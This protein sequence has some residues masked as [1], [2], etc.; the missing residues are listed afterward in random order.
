MLSTKFGIKKK[1]KSVHYDDNDDKP[2]SQQ[3]FITGGA[4]IIIGMHKAQKNTRCKHCA[5]VENCVTRVV[6]QFFFLFLSFILRKFSFILRRSVNN[7]ISVECTS[8]LTRAPVLGEQNKSELVIFYYVKLH[9][10][11]KT[12]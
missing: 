1:K 3:V 12:C 6:F 11:Y 8:L 10:Y 7:K 2:D 9:S 5:R 4:R